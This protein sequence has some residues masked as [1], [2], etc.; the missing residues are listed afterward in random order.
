MNAH[1]LLGV[2][3]FTSDLPAWI[4]DELEDPKA[5]GEGR[6]EPHGV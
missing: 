5:M 1:E 4:F 3:K 2:I 6:Y